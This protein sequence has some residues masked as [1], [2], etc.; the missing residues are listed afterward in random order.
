MKSD[1]VAQAELESVI[2]QINHTGAQIGAIDS[3]SENMTG[4]KQS[5]GKSI[6][7]LELVEEVCNLNPENFQMAD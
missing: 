5:K 4:I 1:D 3:K 2:N 6:R 7:N